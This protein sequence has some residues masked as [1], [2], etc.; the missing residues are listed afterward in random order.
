MMFFEVTRKLPNGVLTKAF[1]IP[2]KE[3]DKI[4]AKLALKKDR[5]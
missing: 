3:I 2:D 4:K 1:Q 5:L